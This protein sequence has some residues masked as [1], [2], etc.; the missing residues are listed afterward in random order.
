MSAFADSLAD[1]RYERGIVS[2]RLTAGR[3]A[4]PGVQL[5]MPLRDF[6]EIVKLLNAELPKI[7]AAHQVFCTA[8]VAEFEADASPAE[9]EKLSLGKKIA[10][11]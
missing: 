6:A 4:S 8:S 11:V 7:E 9:P 2:F 5:F 3:V 10:S 1:L